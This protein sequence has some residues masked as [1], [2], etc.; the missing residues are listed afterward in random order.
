[1]SKSLSLL[2][3]GRR[4]VLATPSCRVCRRWSCAK[5]PRRRLE[6]SG[7]AAAVKLLERE[8]RAFTAIVAASSDG[9]NRAGADNSSHWNAAG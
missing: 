8:P 2:E 6:E 5:P 9:D 7:F 1:M 3:R 4:T